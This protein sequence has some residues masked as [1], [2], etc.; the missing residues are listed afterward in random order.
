MGDGVFGE[1]LAELRRQS[2]LRQS[3]LAEK[4]GIGRS[5]LANVERGRE[6][7]SPRL[8][9]RIVET[10]PEWPPLLSEAYLW[11]R[12]GPDAVVPGVDGYAGAEPF[13]GG[14]FELVS[15]SYGYVFEESRSPGEIIEVRRVRAT[16][17]RAGS[18]G[19][20]LAHNGTAGRVVEQHSLWGG[21]LT[22]TEAVAGDGTPVHWSRFDFDRRLRKGEVHEFAIRT[23]VE[24]DPD[25]RTAI[26]FNLTLP[27]KVVSVHAAFHG[28]VRPAAAWAFG[29]L[30]AGPDGDVPASECSPIDVRD[31]AAFSAQFR[32]PELGKEYG[33]GWAWQA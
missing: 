6:R 3:D 25:P 13:L 1:L 4:L 7:P 30:A 27:A 2:G 11:A 9:H 18:F 22:S 24:R 20:R 17:S 15:L 19:L 26:R 23:W 31:G 33:V 10:L 16:E 12:G 28:S 21:R 29:P 14:P 32:R 8:W 5:T